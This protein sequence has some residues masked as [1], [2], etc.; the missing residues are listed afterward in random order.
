MVN[1]RFHVN[2]NS[3]CADGLWAPAIPASRV[4]SGRKQRARIEPVP[5]AEEV[6]LKEVGSE[7][8][9]RSPDDRITSEK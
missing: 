5:G 9:P 2:R 6:T 4:H 1:P 8:R 3:R 7:Q